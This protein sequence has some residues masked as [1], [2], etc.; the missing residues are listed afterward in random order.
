MTVRVGTVVS[1]TAAAA[2]VRLA[3]EVGRRARRAVRARGR[4]VLGVSGGRTPEG[5]F[6]RLAA[7]GGAPMPWK[8][9]DLCWVDERAVPP[10]DPRSNFGGVERLLLRGLGPERP[11]VHR[12]PGEVRPL[13]RAAERYAADLA[14]LLGGR[15][16]GPPPEVTFDLALLGV[17]P[18]G[19]V[20]SL[21]PGSPRGRKRNGWVH[22]VRRAPVTPKVPRLTVSA[23]FLDRS[24]AAAF[25]VTGPAKRQIVEGILARP[26]SR[27]RRWPAARVVPQESVTWYLDRNVAPRRPRGGPPRA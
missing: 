27:R 13:A 15:P 24:R 26:P 11:R 23:A 17:G 2:D 1:A 7:G 5:L 6:R 19:H 25:L 20:A 9:T 18:D 12:I 3:A 10:G 22:V 8:Q 4:F 14:A 16:D 21:F